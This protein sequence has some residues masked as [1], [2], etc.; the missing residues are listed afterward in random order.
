MFEFHTAPVI[1]TSCTLMLET[2]EIVCDLDLQSNV[3]IIIVIKIIIIIIIVICHAR[4]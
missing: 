3:V 1:F 2:H 4:N